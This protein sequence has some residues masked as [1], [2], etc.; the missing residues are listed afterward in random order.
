MFDQK[1]KPTP[2]ARGNAT[3]STSR[4]SHICWA[5][6]L[7]RMA[8]Y[9]M[10]TCPKCGGL[11]VMSRPVVDP[12]DIQQA[13]ASRGMMAPA[14]PLECSP[15]RGP[16]TTARSHQMELRLSGSGAAAAAA[17]ATTDLTG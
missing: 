9:E 3:S 13:L 14:P 6:L 10:E 2:Q 7:K 1:G 17:V 15:S 11:L 12:H 5:L 8:G 4:L 16:P